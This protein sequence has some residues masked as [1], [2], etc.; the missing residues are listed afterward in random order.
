MTKEDLLE[1]L[2]IIQETKY[3]TTTLE[4][5][6]AHGG[7]P[8]IYDTVSSFSNQLEGGVIVFGVD[9]DH[10]FA[11]VGVYD[12]Q[13]IQKK[14]RERCEEMTPLV[15][16]VLTVADKDGKYFVSA[17]IPGLDIINRPCYRSSQGKLQ[18]SYIRVGDSDQRMTEQEIYD[19]EAFKKKYED[20]IRIM[21]N[22]PAKALEPY[23]VTNYLLEFRREKKSTSNLSDE[24]ILDIMSIY[25]EDHP[26]LSSLL[27]FGKYPQGYVPN[28]CIN[29]SVVPGTEIGDT[30]EHNKRF[31]DSERIEGKLNEMLDEAVAFVRRNE[32]ISITIDQNGKRQDGEEYPVI[33]IREAILNALEHRDYSQFAEGKPVQVIM[34]KDRLEIHSPGGLFGRM[35]M[36]D[37][38]KK[39]PDARNPHLVA[40]LELLGMTENRYSGIPTIRNEME[41]AG[42]PEPVFLNDRGTF[43]VRLFN[44][45]DRTSEEAMN[46]SVKSKN[47]TAEEILSYCQTPR[48]RK[49][50]DA[51]LGLSS[52]TYAFNRYIK[53]L[54]ASGDILLSNPEMPTSRSQLFSSA[55]S[56]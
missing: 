52:S 5:K 28:L 50:L 35:E 38:G 21:E 31:I 16:P 14:I 6:A 49:E 43:I 2:D 41:K 4:V 33:A 25:K 51:F 47:R 42:L 11:E 48:T 15:R 1:L 17:E 13:L 46:D 32:K 34:F 24:E 56:D 53:P 30:G 23:A 44:N 8:K 3:E 55:K 40:M 7:C 22:V 45:D 39:Q 20:D 19:I 54:I 10:N 37:L 29:A 12:A 26:S 27:M 36:Q 9:E 18:S